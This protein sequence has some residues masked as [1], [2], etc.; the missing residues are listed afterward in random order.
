MAETEEICVT[1][2]EGIA[3]GTTDHLPYKLFATIRTLRKQKHRVTWRTGHDWAWFDISVED[4]RAVLDYRPYVK[5]N[6]THNMELGQLRITFADAERTRIRLYEWKGL[7]E[8]HFQGIE[9][10][11]VAPHAAKVGRYRPTKKSGARKKHRAKERPGQLA[12]RRRLMLAYGGRCCVTGCDVAEALDGAHIDPFENKSHDHP[13]NGLLLRKDLHSLFDQGLMS[14]DPAN[15]RVLLA[16]EC[17]SYSPYHRLHDSASIA[18][19]LPGFEAYR[20]DPAALQ[21]RWRCFRSEHVS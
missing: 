9:F 17:L 2:R 7:K 3:K 10:D 12:F 18:A 4:R 1:W 15:G 20:P 21:R 6:S 16:D 14:I 19:P 5:L 13:A 11:L 8:R